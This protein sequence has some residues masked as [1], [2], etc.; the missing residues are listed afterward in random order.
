MKTMVFREKYGQTALIAGASE[1]MGEA[2]ARALAAR[3]LDLVLIARRKE[4]L[5]KA[6]GQIAEQF[7]VKVLPIVCDLG[8]A[9]ATEQ[10]VH[11]IGDTA[12]DF[13]VYNAAS[14]F[15]G[16]YLETGLSTHLDIAAVNVLT[17]LA[18]L[19][20]FG[21]KMVERRKGGIVIMASI[22][23]FQ[24]SGYLSTY[25]ATKAFDR[26]LAEG[27]WYEWKPRG[28]DVI[29]CCAGATATPNYI[30]TRPG[31]ASRLEPKPQ[32]PAQVAEECLRRIGTT[33]SFVSGTGNKWVSFLMQRIFSR[34]K[35]IEIMGDGM[36]KMYGIK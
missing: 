10:V 2:Y 6:A 22:A 16:P 3:G 35:A 33:P 8:A 25:A 28:V 9:D 13:L 11:A 19:F 32:A 21:G 29:A 36:R 17:P 34:K 23:G 26:V 24:G 14:S 12:I 4:P 1:G 18:M 5:E 7:G 27:L 30:N 31:K 20:Y 15:I